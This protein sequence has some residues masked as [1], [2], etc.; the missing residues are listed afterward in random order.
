MCYHL[1]LAAH[2]ITSIELMQKVDEAKPDQQHRFRVAHVKFAQQGIVA[3]LT[4]ALGRPWMWC[5]PLRPRR[6]YGVDWLS[7]VRV[8]S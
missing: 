8:P 3:N 4:L 1:N 6:G 5:L 2:Q 7:G